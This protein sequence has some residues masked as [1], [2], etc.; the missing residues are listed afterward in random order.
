MKTGKN[1]AQLLLTLDYTLSVTPTQI[2]RVNLMRVCGRLSTNISLV[3]IAERGGQSYG[4]RFFR[5]CRS[6]ESQ[7]HQH[8]EHPSADGALTSSS[9]VVQQTTFGNSRREFRLPQTTPT[10]ARVTD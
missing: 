7:G 4:P 9:D 3:T 5:F 6:K 2:R 1:I 8:S 10:T